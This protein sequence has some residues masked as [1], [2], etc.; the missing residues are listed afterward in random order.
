MP[1]LMVDGVSKSYRRGSWALD[2][3]HM[4]VN[5][6]EV[7]AVLGPNGAGK[8]TLVRIIS[9]LL[10]PT[11]GTVSVL[12][13]DVVRSPGD[14]RRLIGYVPQGA[15]APPKSTGEEYLAMVAALHGVPP[16]HRR[17][18]I[19]K[20]LRWLELAPVAR[21]L[22]ETYSGGMRRRLDLAAAL[23]HGP[24]V[25]IFDEPTT[26]L[27]PA[28]R[29]HIWDYVRELVRRDGATLLLTTHYLEEAD[30]LADRIVILDR[31]KVAASGCPGD[32]KAA[33]GGDRV[34]LTVPSG[35]LPAVRDTLAASPLD[36]VP[37]PTVRPPEPGTAS[38]HDD[39][40]EL[41][42]TLPAGARL[43]ARLAETL[44]SAGITILGISVSPPSLEDVF[45]AHTGRTLQEAQ[46]QAVAAATARSKF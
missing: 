36:G 37:D 3:I 13:R 6:G 19:Q 23:V 32:L 16:A 10:A 24:A 22:T 44:H 43:A 8:T 34:C 41:E 17:Y 30:A 40:V 12:G 39:T 26:G 4:Q 7:V 27:D 38:G 46:K 11:T 33:L 20:L 2:G 18:R 29:R 5:E 1:V 31:G 9:T 15:T 45:Q 21:H 35:E 28:S 42:W 25:L 14:V